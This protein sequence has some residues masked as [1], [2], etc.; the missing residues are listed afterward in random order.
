MKIIL[1]G[2]TG[3]I[4][5]AVLQR[6]LSSS[7]I[8]SIVSISRRDP[9]ITH[10][11]LSIILHNDFSTYPHHI[12]EELKTADTCIY[13]LGTNI[14]VKPPS[15]NRKINFEYALAT[16]RIFV[17]LTKGKKSPTRFV[18]LSGALV[19]KDPNKTLWF[20]QENRRMRGELENALLKLDQE[21]TSSSGS[22]IYIVRPGF[23]Q[24][25]GAVIRTWVIGKIANAIL[26]EDLAVAMVD[27][28]LSGSGGISVENRELK[29]IA[30]SVQ[31][32][33]SL[34]AP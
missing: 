2:S 11:K 13:C 4:G 26:L 33:T 29:L 30:E 24:P 25:Q 15:L 8:T 28:A 23:V 20:V 6:C 32:T 5:H 3:Y 21:A 17:E 22:R 27:V 18:Y 16:L 1:F 10:P 19:E 34:Q 9:G 12:L 14:P 7:L 31:K